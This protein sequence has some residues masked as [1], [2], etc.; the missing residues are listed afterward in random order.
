MAEKPEPPRRRP[1]P[2]QRGA[3][4]WMMMA[5]ALI[6]ED[7]PEPGDDGIVF[8]NDDRLVLRDGSYLVLREQA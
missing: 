4:A 5:A 1:T 7:T 6:E 8:R 2:G 3:V